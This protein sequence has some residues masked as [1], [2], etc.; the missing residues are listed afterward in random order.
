MAI[1]NIKK[2]LVGQYLFEVLRYSSKKSKSS[3]LEEMEIHL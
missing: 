1:A 2:N 3:T